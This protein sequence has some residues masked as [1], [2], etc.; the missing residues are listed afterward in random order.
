VEEDVEK[1]RE[2]GEVDR[3]DE[4]GDWNQDPSGALIGDPVSEGSDRK[5]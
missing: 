4:H 3:E 5:R 2:D 1:A